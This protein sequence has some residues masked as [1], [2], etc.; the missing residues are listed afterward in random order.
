ME[1]IG[2]RSPSSQP[3][4]LP[5]HLQDTAT[6][7]SMSP[8]EERDGMD[9]ESPSDMGTM[10]EYS[11]GESLRRADNDGDDAQRYFE[12]EEEEEEEDEGNGQG[13]SA[14]PEERYE[15]YEKLGQGNFGTVYRA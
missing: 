8:V 11:G 10:R 13:I 1:K 6:D 7:Y 5:A 4:Y 14:G 12:G 15:L 3:S 2:Y 9:L